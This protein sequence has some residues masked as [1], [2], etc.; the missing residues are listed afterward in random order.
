MNK[1]TEKPSA[2]RPPESSH[3]P[4][5]SSSEK[6]S[7]APKAKRGL[8][9]RVPRCRRTKPVT[10][11][12]AIE[13]VPGRIVTKTAT[14]TDYQQ[15][16]LH[17]N[18][19]INSHLNA[20]YRNN[21]CPY[22]KKDKDPELKAKRDYYEEHP[23]HPG[24]I[25]WWAK[26]PPVSGAKNCEADEWPPARLYHLNDG[27]DTLQG[28]KGPRIINKPQF[29]RLMDGNQNGRAGSLW[30][31]CPRVAER[32]DINTEYSDFTGLD[33]TVTSS[34]RVKAAYTRITMQIEFKGLE[35][36]DNDDGLQANVC[37][38]KQQGVDH[39]GF[40]LLNDDPWYD[41]NPD[42]KKLRAAYLGN[43]NFKRSWIDPDQIAV[44]EV[45]SSKRM[46]D[47]ERKNDFGWTRCARDGC[48]Q[49]L[50]DLPPD[51]AVVYAP[52]PDLPVQAPV[53]ASTLSVAPALVNPKAHVTPQKG[54]ASAD[55]PRRTQGTG[56][57]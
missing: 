56:Y 14:C 32:E 40:A 43:P 55:Y 30:R 39:R 4:A 18:S 8:E 12:T 44:V 36:P 2:T 5:K 23:K 17:Y 33:N 20:D 25:D 35:Q 6:C 53:T 49:E 50:A 42:A 3:K 24:A 47:A 1:P 10:I 16:C 9:E 21:P 48:E 7:Q 51:A 13:D 45:N 27:Y 38:P 28:N 22:K 11:T 46:T 52:P 26:I 54:V 41:R 19:I 57:M 31:G 37:Q 15:P 29:I 34:T